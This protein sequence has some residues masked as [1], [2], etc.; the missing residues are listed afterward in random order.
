MSDKW[1]DWYKNLSLDLCGSFRYGETITYEL[2][3]IYLQDCDKIEDWGCGAG[4]FKRFFVNDNTNK[5]I[6][7][8]G[9]KTPFADIKTDLTTY[10]SNVDGIFM[11]HVLEH[12]YDWKLILENTCKSFTKKMCLV[13][14][15]P[16]S[17]ETIQ[18]AHNLQNGVDVPDISFDKNELINIFEKY[19]INYELS[20][21]T[22]QTG[23]NIEHVFYLQKEYTQFTP[24][25][26]SNIRSYNLAFYTYFYGSNNNIACR[27][28]E[29]PSLKYNCY[30]Y[31]NNKTIF[32]KLKETN[33]IGI[34][35]DTPTND[36][37]IESCMVGKRVKTL[38][39]EYGELRDYDYLCFL[40][41]KLDKVNEDL[42]EKFIHEYFLEQNYA[43]LL[44][45][46]WY[47]N[48][49]IWDEFN[50]SIEQER[51]AFESEKYK[52]Y[53]INQINAGFTE[54]TQHH[55]ACG[56]LIRNM[57]HEKMTEIN[58]T[59]YSHIQECGIQD[60]I[61]FFFVKQLFTDYILPFTE[62]PF[63]HI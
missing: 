15:T 51:Y 54:T 17:D 7:I 31:T 63:I 21:L 38:S 41:S 47:T 32:E 62:Y 26:I 28:P 43:L 19:H 39:H 25:F 1:N 60:Q 35:D 33:W 40:D 36:D 29:L 48:G 49:N 9:S 30:Y 8:D 61:S 53:I 46:H 13:L 4:G 16:F 22:T 27:I 3:Y 55:C 34:Y 12:N 18:I 10:S 45:K 20:T 6:G 42:V 58:T 23:Y 5:Y 11:R 37:L 52:K 2:G 56:F 50:N 24:E 59:W 44:R 14:F 57:K